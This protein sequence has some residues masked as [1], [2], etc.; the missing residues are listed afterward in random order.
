LKG[1]QTSSG[2]RASLLEA[3][4]PPP[5]ARLVP[6]AIKATQEQAIGA[7]VNPRFSL[8]GIVTLDSDAVVTPA[9]VATMPA[10]LAVKANVTTWAP[11]KMTIQLQ[12]AAPQP[13]YLLVSENWYKDWT[14]TVDG[15]AAP[16][17]RGDVSLITV[18]VPAGAKEVSLVFISTDYAE[19]RAITFL[20]CAIALLGLVVPPVL[21]KRTTRDG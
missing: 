10:P 12:P 2:Y 9:P 15:K 20:S 1:V 8:D 3:N 7:V 16:V 4:V 13:A 19:G 17:L 14:A 18:P 11:G 21:R 6:A 5:Y